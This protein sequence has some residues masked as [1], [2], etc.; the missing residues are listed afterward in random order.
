MSLAFLNG[1]YLPLEQAK[2]SVLDRGFTFA[3]GVYEVIPV[4][5]KRIFRLSEHLR[6]LDDSL[7]A[8]Y[9]TPPLNA[10]QWQDILEILVTRNTTDD[11]SLYIQVTRGVSAREHAIDDSIK[12]TV[13]AMSC[14]Q[15]KNNHGSGVTAITEQD[16]RWQ[17]CHIKAITLLPSVMLRHRAN[18]AG[19]EEA[20]LIKD[21]FVTEG[22]ASNVFIVKDKVVKT[23]EKNGRLL[24]GITRDL[25]VELLPT[26]HVECQELMI[27]EEELNQADEI[28][29]TSSGWEIMPVVSLNQNLVSDGKPG[30]IWRRAINAFQAFKKTYG[31]Q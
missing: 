1:E 6:R 30:A 14:P 9:L 12:P 29:L 3:D 23:P 7:T 31:K 18:Q 5:N 4:Y 11:Q 27:T 16:I 26:V 21:G 25:V 8:I 17:Y 13:F 19:A 24:P 10:Q 20:I 2:I 28:W 22:A 15:P